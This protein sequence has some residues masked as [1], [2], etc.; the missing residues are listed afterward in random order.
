MGEEEV[1]KVLGFVDTDGGGSIGFNEFIVTAITP[2]D[3]LNQKTLNKA[4][5]IFDADKGGTISPKEFMNALQPPG[6]DFSY[7]PDMS[8]NKAFDLKPG[9][10]PHNYQKE[11]SYRDFHKLLMRILTI[12]HV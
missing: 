1:D 2:K 11:M 12:D 9:S 8:W 6:E 4:Y 10:N 7:I 3:L 5:M